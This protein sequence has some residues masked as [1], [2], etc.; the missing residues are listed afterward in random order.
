MKVDSV[1]LVKV[2]TVVAVEMVDS[3]IMV[4]VDFVVV[5]FCDN[6]EVRSCHDWILW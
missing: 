6:G 4:K 5:E 2:V 3:V 1:M